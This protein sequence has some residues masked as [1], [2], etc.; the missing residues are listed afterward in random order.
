MKPADNDQNP[1]LRDPDVRLMLRA[2]AGDEAAF[3]QLV[4][5]YQDRLFGV[6]AHL[7]QSREWAED[8]AQEVFL[9]I[10]RARQGYEPT[11][12]FSTWLFQIANNLAR[13][14]RR[15]HGRRKEVGMIADE[16]G[17]S[18][19]RPGSAGI[20]DKSGLMPTRV[21]EKIEMCS[22]VQA[23]LETLTESQRMAV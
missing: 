11:A 22:V 6:L 7:L 20:P 14:L 13:N 5:N 19:L 15:D 3:S 10:Y 23:A 12:R 21:S 8:L 16:S 1:F 18:G 4:A 9:R 17:L 2:K